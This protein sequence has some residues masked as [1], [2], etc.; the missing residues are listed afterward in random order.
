AAVS[1]QLSSPVF[2][3]GGGVFKAREVFN[4][5]KRAIRKSFSSAPVDYTPLEPL[6]GAFII[7]KG[8]EISPELREK[9]KEINKLYA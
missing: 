3:V 7:A 2:F 6:A 8:E 9:L 1:L 4:S 5:F